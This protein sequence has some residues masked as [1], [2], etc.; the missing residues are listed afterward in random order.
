MLRVSPLVVYSFL[1][2][3]GW[4]Y[5]LLYTAQPF[6]HFYFCCCFFYFVGRLHYLLCSWCERRLWNEKCTLGTKDMWKKMGIQVAGIWVTEMGSICCKK[7]VSSGII[8]SVCSWA[9]LQLMHCCFQF[10][11][12][13]WCCGTSSL[14]ARNCD[15]RVKG[16]ALETRWFP[17]LRQLWAVVAAYVGCN[18]KGKSTKWQTVWGCNES[19]TPRGLEE[20]YSLYK[21]ALSCPELEARS[22]GFCKSNSSDIL[23]RQGRKFTAES[24]GVCRVMILGLPSGKTGQ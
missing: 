10:A 18:K 20:M 1:F 15:N 21:G 5:I 11:S 8:P 2:K 14:M 13:Y 6:F 4:S 16:A 17:L 7:I 22:S 23:G 3:I 19:A 9:P 24:S 12:R